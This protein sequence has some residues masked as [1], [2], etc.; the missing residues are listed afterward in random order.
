MKNQLPYMQQLLWGQAWLADITDY[1]SAHY[2]MLVP[3]YLQDGLRH[4]IH[5]FLQ[6]NHQN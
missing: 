5:I 3:C 4:Y 6:A 2:V 1:A